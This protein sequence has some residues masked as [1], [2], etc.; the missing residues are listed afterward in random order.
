MSIPDYCSIISPSEMALFDKYNRV[1]FRLE[2]RGLDTFQAKDL[3]H[4]SRLMEFHY[5]DEDNE[6]LMESL[7]YFENPAT[8]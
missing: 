7:K 4:L 2:L 8:R 3:P 1:R 5:L 6:K